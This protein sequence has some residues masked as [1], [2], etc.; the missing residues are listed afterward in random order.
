MGKLLFLIDGFV[1]III[2]S[3]F[4]EFSLLFSIFISSNS[5]YYTPFLLLRIKKD[6]LSLAFFDRLKPPITGGFLLFQPFARSL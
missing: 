6:Q 3:D 1:V 2:L 5:R 4:Q